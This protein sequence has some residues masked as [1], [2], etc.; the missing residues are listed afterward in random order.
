MTKIQKTSSSTEETHKIA[1]EFKISNP[2]IKI[3]LLEGNLGSGKTVFTKGLARS[4]GIAIHQ[5]KSPTFSIVERHGCLSHFDL[6]RLNHLEAD[7][8]AF[9]EEEWDSDRTTVFEWPNKIENH[10]KKPYAKVS[11]EHGVGSVR[12]IN[13]E[14]FLP[15]EAQQEFNP[16]EVR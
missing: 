10:I 11:I 7:L 5:V 8:L 1:E 15:S 12:L 3:W 4:L 2:E 6:Y 13:L 16:E 14:L 9:I